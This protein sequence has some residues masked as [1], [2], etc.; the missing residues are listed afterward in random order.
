M[1]ITKNGKALKIKND[2]VLLSTWYPSDVM[3]LKVENDSVLLTDKLG[4]KWWRRI[5]QVPGR[6]IT[7]RNEAA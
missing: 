3:A 6:F 7:Y 1:K 2:E 5:V 4:V